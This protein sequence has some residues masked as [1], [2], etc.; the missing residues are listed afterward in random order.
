MK[1]K[2]FFDA[3]GELETKYVQEAL[4]YKKPVRRSAWMRW[5]A[6]GTTRT[7]KESGGRNA[8]AF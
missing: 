8:P 2:Q 7:G 6:N 1:V 3:M 4:T 5:G